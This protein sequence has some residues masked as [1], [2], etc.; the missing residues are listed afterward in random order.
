MTTFGMRPN[1]GTFS[2]QQWAWAEKWVGR[3]IDW[4]VQMADR[5][6]PDAMKGSVNGNLKNIPAEIK[7]RLNVVMTVPLGFGR[8]F[9]A[10]TPAGRTRIEQN[11]DTVSAGKYDADYRRV[12]AQLAAAGLK[13]VVI[14][15]GHE[16]SGAWY[17]W[18]AVGNVEPY[19]EAF[20]HVATI[21]KQEAPKALIEYNLAVSGIDTIGVDAFPG[22]DVVNI[23]GLD[24]YNKPQG[25]TTFKQRWKN[26]L[27][28]ALTKHL[29][30]ANRW[31][32]PVSF[33]EWGNQTEDCPEYIDNMAAWFNELGT[34]LRYQSLFNPPRAEYRIPSDLY[35]RSTKTYLKHYGA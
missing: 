2:A 5:G 14:R 11:L 28:P 32:K 31:Q 15:L 30:M 3:R 1:G 4:T 18:S 35:P 19:I 20:R 8:G 6:N 9:N 17:P 25:Q 34:K 22:R 13:S 23:I 24:I 21:A 29:E 16:A 33:A 7:P 12:F 10:K 26:K 27:Q